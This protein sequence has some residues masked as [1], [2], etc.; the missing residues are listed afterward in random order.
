M[1]K[2]LFLLYIALGIYLLTGYTSCPIEPQVYNSPRTAEWQCG[3]DT[4]YS[5]SEACPGK[6][7]IGK[8]KFHL[9]QVGITQTNA[10]CYVRTVCPC[11]LLKFHPTPSVLARTARLKKTPLP[12]DKESFFA[13]PT[14]FTRYSSDYYIFQLNRILI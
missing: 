3:E 6:K 11:K 13:P 7:E 2:Y 5:I 14:L 4:D 12:E 9:T 8:E 10:S 1:T